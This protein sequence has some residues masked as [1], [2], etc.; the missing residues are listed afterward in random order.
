MQKKDGMTLS[1]NIQEESI[2]LTVTSTIKNSKT[3]KT[4]MKTFWPRC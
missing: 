4:T 1:D 2:L 3:G